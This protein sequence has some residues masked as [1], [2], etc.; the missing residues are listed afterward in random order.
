MFLS[1]LNR[2]KLN[3]FKNLEKADHSVIYY[4]TISKQYVSKSWHSISCD[5]MFNVV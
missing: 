4:T 2:S 3:S 1:N 5:R